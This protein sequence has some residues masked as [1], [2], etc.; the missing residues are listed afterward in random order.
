MAKNTAAAI[1]QLEKQIITFASEKQTTIGV[2]DDE[3]AGKTVTYNGMDYIFKP[4]YMNETLATG[5]YV[6]NSDGNA[7]VALV[8]DAATNT[9]NGVTTAQNAFRPYF[10]ATAH[11][12]GGGGGKHMLPE[13]IVFGGNNGE[14]YEEGP[15]T[16]LNGGIEISTRGRA[17]IVKSNMK[18]DTTIRI[19]NVAGVTVTSY[20]L[21]PGKTVETPVNAHGTYVVNR[22]K[23]FVQ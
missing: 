6:L 12:G 5:D 21:E 7:Y 2:S 19:V 18:V 4:S 20:V 23:I 3:M 8:A 1:S 17:I 15:E 9:A 11:V 10:V 13:R 16:E 14:L 22:K